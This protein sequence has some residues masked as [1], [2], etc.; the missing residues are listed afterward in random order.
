MRRG[1]LWGEEIATR[2]TYGSPM[3]ALGPLVDKARRLPP[4][5]VDGA[6]GAGIFA[7][8]ASGVLGTPASGD[9]P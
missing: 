9:N 4:I 3:R 7:L 2:P 1:I 6:I 8:G 5:A